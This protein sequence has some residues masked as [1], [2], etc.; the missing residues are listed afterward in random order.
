M[1]VVIEKQ[2]INSDYMLEMNVKDTANIGEFCIFMRK[3]N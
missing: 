2:G 3:G 1:M